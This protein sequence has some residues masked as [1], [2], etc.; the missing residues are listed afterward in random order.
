L[1]TRQGKSLSDRNYEIY[2]MNGDG[3]EH[4]RLTHNP[5]FDEWPAWPSSWLPNYPAGGLEHSP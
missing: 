5:R 2:V 3:S 1:R 4:R